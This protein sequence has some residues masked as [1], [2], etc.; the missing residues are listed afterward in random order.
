MK[1]YQTGTNG[2]WVGILVFVILI[3]S[4]LALGGFLLGTPLG[5][6]LLTFLVI[7]H[8]Y[9]RYQKRK[10][11]EQYNNSTYSETSADQTAAYGTENEFAAQY[12]QDDSETKFFTSEDRNSA[13][14]VEFK[15]L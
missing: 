6:A 14:D 9:R 10:Y 12:R 2:L 5:L 7:R 11:Y 1:I 4:M 15:E 13:V 8:F 3:L